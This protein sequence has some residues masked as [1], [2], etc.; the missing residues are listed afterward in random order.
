MN[1][2]RELLHTTAHDLQAVAD[3]TTEAD[4]YGIPDAVLA[5]PPGLTI[6]EAARALGVIREAIRQR[7]RRGTLAAAKVDGHWY[8]QVN[9]HATA[10]DMPTSTAAEGKGPA[11]QHADQGTAEPAAGY[12]DQY[13]DHRELVDALR[14]EVAFLRSEL[15]TRTEELRRKDTIIMALAQRV[16][17]LP[18]PASSSPPPTAG[19]PTAPHQPHPP[20]W[21]RVVAVFR[22]GP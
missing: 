5:S 1:A 17:A 21:R 20:W 10:T 2:L 22:A 12:A 8:V 15:E 13:A 11:D 19:P 7:I 6:S 3:P 18:A 9:D 14:D 16:P 4:Q